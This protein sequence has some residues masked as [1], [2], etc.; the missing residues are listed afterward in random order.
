MAQRVSF[1][2]SKFREIIIER[3]VASI[4]TLISFILFILHI[5]KKISLDSIAVAILIVAVFPW[6][7]PKLSSFLEY[8]SETLRNTN[9]KSI[10]IPHIL[11]IEQLERK[12]EKTNEDIAKTN[13]Y[14]AELFALSM[15]RDTFGQLK[16]LNDGWTG[17]YYLDPAFKVGLADELNHLKSLGYIQ[18]D[19]DNRVK[20][21][22]DLPS[23]NQN[24]L[25][26]YISVTD[27]GKRF[28][29][30]REQTSEH[31]GAA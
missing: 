25:S 22:E 31:L 27:T 20:G 28:I 18:F 9:I 10:E 30:L 11:R 7:I 21:V 29:K 17:H 6:I 14:I 2:I 8:F 24:N 1:F 13:E 12:V 23:G 16:K 26:Q 3:P 4:M 5:T 15:S 19:K